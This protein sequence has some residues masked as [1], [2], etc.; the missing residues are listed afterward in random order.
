MRGPDGVERCGIPRGDGVAASRCVIRSGR[1]GGLSPAHEAA[2]VSVGQRRERK[3]AAS[4]KELIHRAALVVVVQ[5]QGICGPQGIERLFRAFDGHRLAGLVL[6][7]GRIRGCGPALEVVAVAGRF[8]G[9]KG[10]AAVDAVERFH[11]AAFV[12]VVQVQDVRTP[13]GVELR[14]IPGFNGIDASRRVIRG[15]RVGGLSPAY[16]AAPVAVGQCGEREAVAASV[17]RS[18]H[19]APVV[20]IQL[21]AVARPDGVERIDRI[22][23]QCS[24]VC[25]GIGR[26]GEVVSGGVL[27][28]ERVRIRGPAAEDIAFPCRRHIGDGIIVSIAGDPPVLL[29]SAVDVIRQHMLFRKDGVELFHHKGSRF[30]GQGDARLQRRRTVHAPIVALCL[31]PA[32]EGIARARRWRWP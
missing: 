9:G 6:G 3:A 10:K 16:E 15:V 17:E 24:L 5:P 27:H 12:I 29:R 31:G 25:E 28:F 14:G 21:Q 1:V 22:R 4:V 7:F 32:A 20:V 19:I 26:E 11:R 18:C 8:L 30:S 2:S 13:Q 23:I